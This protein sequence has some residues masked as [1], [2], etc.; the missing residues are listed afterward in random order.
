MAVAIAL[1]SASGVGSRSPALV[2]GT[3]VPAH[4]SC[5]WGKP[6][7]AKVILEIVLVA[8]SCGEKAVVDRRRPAPAKHN[9]SERGPITAPARR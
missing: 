8:K 2:R 6:R 9:Q 7:G 5:P 1:S 3:L 4:A